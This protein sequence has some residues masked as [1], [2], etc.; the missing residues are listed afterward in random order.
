MALGEILKQKRLERNFTKEYISD[1]THMMAATIE[2]LESE[3]FAKIPAALYGRGFIKTYCKVLDIDP[4]PLIDEYMMH[5]DQNYAR[6]KPKTTMPERKL[7]PVAI[8]VT[9]TQTSTN[10]ATNALP[11]L[12]TAGTANL[13]AATPS[14]Q[15]PP[16]QPLY[17]NIPRPTMNSAPVEKPTE[18]AFTLEGDEVPA[19]ATP[20]EA[21]AQKVR[22]YVTIKEARAAQSAYPTSSIED[23]QPS[24]EVSIFAPHRPAT[25]PTRP[26][27]KLLQAIFVSIKNGCLRAKQKVSSIKTNPKIRRIDADETP[28]LLSRQDMLHVAYVFIGLVAITLIFFI[29]RWIFN[30]SESSERVESTTSETVVLTPPE[31]Y[32]Q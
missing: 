16:P 2:A 3:D 19:S 28:P 5:V 11:R 14:P 9:S 6:Q 29:F 22:R 25:N 24:D 26:I 27:F 4:Q 21:P 7:R 17:T 12:V 13:R 15:P 23:T 18:D 1:R 30:E 20:P 10:T 8:P 31:P 32:F